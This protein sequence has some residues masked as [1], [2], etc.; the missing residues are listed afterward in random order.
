MPPGSG[1][2][3]N[4][5]EQKQNYR[6][7]VLA[8]GFCGLAIGTKLSALFIL[9]FVGL[10]LCVAAFKHRRFG[11]PLIFGMIALVVALPWLARSFY[12]TGNPVFPLAHSW[13]GGPWL[14]GV[15]HN[16][17]WKPDYAQAP[18]DNMLGRSDEKSLRSLLILP[19]TLTFDDRFR[20]A[21]A[22][23]SPLYLLALPLL[24]V[25]AIKATAANIQVTQ[26]VRLILICTLAFTLCWFFTIQDIRY[27]TVVIPM[28]SIATAAAIDRL[29]TWLLR[30]RSWGEH[31]LVWAMIFAIL[32]AP[33]WFYCQ[34]RWE[35]YGPIPVTE[36]EREA[37]L[38]HR[39][40]LYPVYR[41]LNQL[42]GDRYTVY[43]LFSPF[44]AYFARGQFIGNFYGPGRYSLMVS[45]RERKGR[46]V[47][48]QTLY[49]RLGQFGAG[50]FLFDS[51]SRDVELP[52]DP[53]FDSHFK[54][55]YA[56]GNGLLFSLCDHSMTTAVGPQRLVNPQF[57]EL[58]NGL[59]LAWSMTGEPAVDSTGE[60]SLSGSVAIRA[61]T[62]DWLETR[63]D[64]ITPGSVYL[65]SVQARGDGK[66][67]PGALTVE[68]HTNDGELLASDTRELLIG[69]TWKSC[70]IYSSAP[71]EAVSAIIRCSG[72]LN[73]A[74]WFDN[75]S[76]AEV[77]YE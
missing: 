5:L 39:L 54:L 64:S 37:Y 68:W 19:W 4:W 52:D 10:L 72:R 48:G 45:G 58:E 1:R 3:G 46:I 20:N 38:T 74:V 69:N 21:P 66:A 70:W 44:M 56:R 9:A 24:V 53:F 75:A 65:L 13:F 73:G 59:P 14:A 16:P 67:E 42:A 47:D 40:P 71:P 51:G 31:A 25:T 60:Q 34:N 43:A 22:A 7:L 62:S 36:K 17:F 26:V 32:A 8:G 18:F 49:T 12:Y 27:Y 50:Y 6:W 11:P 29:L 2:S 41:H 63:V 35:I 28:L 33:A 77:V 55:I 23:I 61:T 57:E 76:F 30:G 15:L